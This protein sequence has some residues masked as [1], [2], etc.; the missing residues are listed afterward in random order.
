[1]KAKNKIILALAG[2]AIISSAMFFYF[3]IFWIKPTKNP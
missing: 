2:W 3:L 1:M